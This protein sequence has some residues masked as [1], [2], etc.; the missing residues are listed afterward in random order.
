MNASKFLAGCVVSLVAL[1]V[2]SGCELSACEEDAS[3]GEIRE[4]SSA[5][6]GT[7]ADEDP[8]GEEAVNDGG[9]CIRFESLTKF[10]G[11]EETKGANWLAGGTV[12]IKSANGRVRVRQG[13]EAGVVSTLFKPFTFR[14]NTKEEEARNQLENKLTKTVAEGSNPGDVLIETSREPNQPTLGSEMIVSLPPEFDGVLIIDQNNGKTEVDF[15]GSAS[16]LSVDSNNGFCEI[17]AGSVPDIDVKCDSS[18]DAT[19]S[20]VPAGAQGRFESD[21]D[22]DI[23]FPSGGTFTVQALTTSGQNVEITGAE[24]AGCTVQEASQESKSA[25]CGGATTDDPIYS[26]EGTGL[27]SDINVR[28]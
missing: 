28:F 10:V 18:I 26:L 21:F 15:V 3:E 13:D 7:A 23:A 14:G 22:I 17:A 9:N 5:D 25:F 8:D 1:G 19:V 27:L 4:S 20:G 6:G 2:A 11:T 16:R 24:G 12:T